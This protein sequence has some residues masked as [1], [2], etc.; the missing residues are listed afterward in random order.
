M[1][2]ERSSDAVNES[3]TTSS[4]QLM[5]QV[6]AKDNM[7]AALRRVQQNGGA[8]G[9]D[10]MAVDELPAFLKANWQSIKTKLLEDKYKPQPVC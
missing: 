10:G 5:E 2:A 4:E 8:S 7:F 6:V 1:G 9:S 3:E